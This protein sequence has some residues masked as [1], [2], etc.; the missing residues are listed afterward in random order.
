MKGNPAASQDSGTQAPGGDREQELYSVES[1]LTGLVWNLQVP[2]VLS[3][4]TLRHTTL[5][6]AP[7]DRIRRSTYVLLELHDLTK[8]VLDALAPFGC[9]VQ[10]TVGRMLH[11]LAL[12]FSYMHKRL[13]HHVAVPVV[14]SYSNSKPRSLCTRADVC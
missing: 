6:G 12:L 13:T 10:A 8:A 1:Y 9:S 5:S 4:Y 11:Q 14:R 2:I 3:A 7:H